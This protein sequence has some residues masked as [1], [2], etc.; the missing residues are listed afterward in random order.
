MPSLAELL[1]SNNPEG[2]AALLNL[3]PE[4]QAS[5]LPPPPQELPQSSPFIPPPMVPVDIEQYQQQ[6]EEPKRESQAKKE[7]SSAQALVDSLKDVK[8]PSAQ[9]PASDAIAKLLGQRS[10]EFEKAKGERS[11][12]E[13]LGLLGKAGEQIGAGIARVRPGETPVSDYLLRKAERPVEDI[14][15]LQGQERGAMANLAMQ[16]QLTSD[17]AKA[18]PN[19]PISQVGRQILLDMSKRAGMKLDPALVQNISLAQQESL[20]K[21]IEGVAS[22]QVMT[23][24]NKAKQDELSEIRR[25]GLNQRIEN[26]T[27][28]RFDKN[29]KDIRGALEGA[30]RIRGFIHEVESGKLVPSANVAAQLTNDI[31]M[32]LAGRGTTALADREKSAINTLQTS[33]AKIKSYALSKPQSAIPKE[34]LNQLKQET[35]IL[36]KK[37]F[38]TFKRASSEM[39]AG[40]KNDDAKD[41]VKNR[42]D[43]FMSSYKSQ[44]GLP[45]SVGGEE[46]EGSSQ[47]DQAIQWAKDN[48][49]DPRA[50]RILKLHGLE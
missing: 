48:K 30:G 22:R 46:K 23:E 9:A 39:Q 35:D 4:L 27:N 3:K 8:A 12:L 28:T 10:E 15:T 18:D 32:L 29:T 49:S 17:V 13:L 19:S 42:H 47:D 20:L 33:I 16:Q 38:S 21:G 43:E 34:Y 2:L 7:P 45:G 5:M 11:K 24:A 26:Q 50:K 41:I 40:L 31:S 36:E 1:G 6:E 37:Y 14:N 44:F 25:Q